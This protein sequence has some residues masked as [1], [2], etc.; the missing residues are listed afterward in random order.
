MHCIEHTRIRCPSFQKNTATATLCPY[1]PTCPKK[2][3]CILQSEFRNVAVTAAHDSAR[4]CFDIVHFLNILI[5]GL[6]KKPFFIIIFV[7]LLTIFLYIF[8][9][10]SICSCAEFTYRKPRQRNKLHLECLS[11]CCLLDLHPQGVSSGHG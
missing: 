3:T 1:T 11:V 9:F 4:K 2:L 5:K 7:S 6:V 8:F 10:F